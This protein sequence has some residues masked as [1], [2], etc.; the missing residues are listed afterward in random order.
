M[1]FVELLKERYPHIQSN[2]YP[3]NEETYASEKQSGLSFAHNTL[4]VH[5]DKDGNVLVLPDSG[6]IRIG[7]I[8]EPD[9][10]DRMDQIIKRLERRL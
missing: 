3:M 9:I 7:D 4:F 8:Y 1:T 2:L 6:W 10:L 5:A